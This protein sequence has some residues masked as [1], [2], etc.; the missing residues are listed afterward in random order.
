MSP[1]VEKTE[2]GMRRTTR[3]PLVLFSTQGHAK[4]T[5]N[6]PQANVLGYFDLKSI[7]VSKT[8]EKIVSIKE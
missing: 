1:I 5:E 6:I 4:Q 2:T 7:K 8:G 3:Y